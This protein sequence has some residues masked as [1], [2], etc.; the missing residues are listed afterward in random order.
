MKVKFL[1]KNE[2]LPLNLLNLRVCDKVCK[3]D[4]M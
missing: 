1:G 3:W 4:P 2:N